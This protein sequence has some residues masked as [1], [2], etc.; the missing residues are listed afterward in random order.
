MI[1]DGKVV[2]W[3]ALNAR[4]DQLFYKG[5]DP[6]VAGAA[7]LFDKPLDSVT[8]TERTMFKVVFT[9]AM[10]F[11]GPAWVQSAFEFA[12]EMV[13]VLRERGLWKEIEAE[14]TKRIRAADEAKR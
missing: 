13:G 12:D 8:R 5:C 2:D 4:L 3:D 9:R 14:A 7:A 10:Q 1:D 6:Y 11:R